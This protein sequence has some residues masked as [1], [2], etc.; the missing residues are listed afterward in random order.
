MREQRKH[1]PWDPY[2]ALY[3]PSVLD[4]P[5]PV[6]DDELVDELTA[7][8]RKDGW[9]GRPL[10]AARH[11]PL[12]GLEHALVCQTGSHRLVAAKAAGIEVV[13]VVVVDCREDLESEPI[14]D[15]PLADLL[16]YAVTK[17]DDFALAVRALWLEED[18]Y[19]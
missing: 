7:S 12:P 4:P 3:H 6:D 18:G 13:P 16:R 17:G 14:L 5:H 10:L 19:Q 2:V 11:P 9:K 8:M 15:D 1:G